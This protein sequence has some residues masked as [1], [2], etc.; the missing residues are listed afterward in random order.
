[1]SSRN[2][3]SFLLSQI[4]APNSTNEAWFQEETER[5][6]AG[7]CLLDILEYLHVVQ[8]FPGRFWHVINA[9]TIRLV[10]TCLSDPKLNRHEVLD[11]MQPRIEETCRLLHA[12]RQET[13]PYYGDDYWDWASV[14]EAFGV[15]REKCEGIGLNDE[16]FEDEVD[17]FYRSV[18]EQLNSR[19]GLSTGDRDREW[20]GPATAAV[21]FRVLKKF[22]SRLGNIDKVLKE[23]EVQALTPVKKGKYR[24]HTVLPLHVLW[25]Y[26]QVMSEFPQSDSEQAQHLADFSWTKEP[27]EKSD[28]ISACA[29][30]RIR[31][32]AQGR[33]QK[34]HCQTT[35]MSEP[36]STTR[37]RTYGRYRQGIT[38][39]SGRALA[40]P[41]GAGDQENRLDD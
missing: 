29:S 40:K 18:K 23:L 10:C 32:K 22:K 17:S 3:S 19:A 27:M 26:G 31:V 35:Q 41:D 12:S 15:V 16:A 9:H 20:Y 11:R 8:M 1:M 30:R 25:H 36:E 39:R 28:R 4:K 13:I 5:G 38:Q 24:G 33:G 34:S 2:P 6:L 37:T 14:I 7:R 21:A